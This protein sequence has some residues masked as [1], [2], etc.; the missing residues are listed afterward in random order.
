MNMINTHLKILI[1]DDTEI[2]LERLF[3]MIAELESVDSVLKS[4]SYNQTVE[5][6]K[7]QAP[8]V[9]LVDLQLPG[10][11]G[12]ELLKYVKRNY[13]AVKTII[14]TNSASEFYRDL[15]NSLGADYFIDKSTEFEKIPGI[16]EAISMED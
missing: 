15:C 14:V 3:D 7:Q 6:I 13:P 16:I 10:K 1:V 4:N 8:D 9:I 2:V 12:I 11:N 5:L